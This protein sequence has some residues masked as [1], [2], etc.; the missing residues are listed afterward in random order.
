[1]DQPH[2]SSPGLDAASAQPAA[3]ALRLKWLGID[4]SQEA[5]IYMRRDC[6]VCRSE[7]FQAQSRVR[8][9]LAGREIIS[10][11]NVIDSELLSHGEASLSVA[12]WRALKAREGSTIRVYPAPLVESVRTLR[13]KIYGHRFDRPG[14]RAILEDVSQG[15]YSDIFLSAFITACAGDRLD[16]RETTWLT[17]A[18]AQCGEQLDW[19]QGPIADKHCVGGLPGNRTTLIVTPIIACA[20]LR[21]PKTSSPQSSRALG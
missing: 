4:T 2:L 3:E 7:G 21:M 20:G 10:T 18:M 14:L 11:L 1:M 16:I 13:A 9:E 8:V 12:G 15:R 17:E 19:G 6:P 5:V